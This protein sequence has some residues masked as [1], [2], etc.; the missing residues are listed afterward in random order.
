MSNIRTDMGDRNGEV[1]LWAFA[2][3]VSAALATAVVGDEDR[4]GSA[5]ARSAKAPAP[6]GPIVGLADRR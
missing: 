3:L 6:S 2:L 5:E 4:N 1:V